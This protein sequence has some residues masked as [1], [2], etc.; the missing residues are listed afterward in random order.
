[1]PCCQMI[2]PTDREE[3]DEGEKSPGFDFS[4]VTLPRPGEKLTIEGQEVEVQEPVGRNGLPLRSKFYSLGVLFKPETKGGHNFLCCVPVVNRNTGETRRCGAALKIPKGSLG[5]PLRHIKQ[6]HPEAYKAIMSNSNENARRRKRAAEMESSVESSLSKKQKLLRRCVSFCASQLLPLDLICKEEFINFVGSLG[7]TGAAAVKSGNLLESTQTQALYNALED[8]SK[9]LVA[10][11]KSRIEEVSSGFYA[12]L[13]FLHVTVDP[14]STPYP[15]IRIIFV[16]DKGEQEEV[17]LVSR[18]ENLA[19]LCLNASNNQLGGNALGED[20]RTPANSA[21][22]AEVL[23]VFE[24]YNLQEVWKNILTF[25]FISKSGDSHKIDLKLKSFALESI[26][27][28]LDLYTHHSDPKAG[29]EEVIRMFSEG[30]KSAGKDEAE[31][32]KKVDELK[33]ELDAFEGFKER[34][35]GGGTTLASAFWQG[36]RQNWMDMGLPLLFKIACSATVAT[37]SMPLEAIQT[38]RDARIIEAKDFIAEDYKVQHSRYT[39][40]TL[41]I[42]YNSIFL[43]M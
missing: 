5:N 21:V 16:N 12:G 7:K 43:S 8:E 3:E 23:A 13:S 31:I 15:V 42:K 20:S 32:E 28:Y 38:G 40:L 36:K 29:R 10:R 11:M 14:R 39:K 18:S 41:L 34:R 30:I 22:I 37:E 9:A 35:K 27:K 17:N 26:A 2:K 19:T 25:S 6:K 33:K 1:M 4:S 24:E